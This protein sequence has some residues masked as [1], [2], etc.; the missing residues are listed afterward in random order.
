M[1]AVGVT[2][3]MLYS[4]PRSAGGRGDKMF[5]AILTHISNAD[6]LDTGLSEIYGFGIGSAVGSTTPIGATVS[7]G[8]LSFV[9]SASNPAGAVIVIGRQ[10]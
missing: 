5:C 7:G 10:D 3:S 8:Q 2:S 4:L 9:T 1:T 6:T